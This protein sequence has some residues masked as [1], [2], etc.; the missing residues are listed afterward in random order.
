MT[1]HHVRSVFVSSGGWARRVAALAFGAVLFG[2]TVA[3]HEPPQG[4]TPGAKGG[5]QKTFRLDGKFV[6][7][8]GRIQLQI[9]NIG[10]TGNQD[11][12]SRTT[13]P[14]CEWPPGSGNDYLYAAGLWVGAIDASGIPHV[15]TAL[16]QRE[17]SPEIIFTTP[18]P[19]APLPT[20]QLADVRESYEGIP[21][22]N[23]VISSSVDPDDDGDGFIDEDFPNGLDDDQDGLCDEDYAATG[24]Q[25]LSAEYFDDIPSIR[26]V[27]PEHVPL[28]I[29]VRQT[30]YAWATPGQNDFVGMDYRITNRSGRTLRNVMVAI[31]AD[32]DVGNRGIQGYFVDDQVGLFDRVVSYPG[33]TGETT[34]RRIQMAYAFDNP[35][36]PANPQENKGGD[37]PGYFGCMFLNHTIDPSG[38]TAP[39]H[40]GVTSF[41]YFSGS[42]SFSAGGDPENDAQRYQLMTDPALNPNATGEVRSS[43]PVDYRFIMATGPFRSLLPESTLTISVGWVMGLGL[44]LPVNVPTGPLPSSAVTAGSVVANAISAQQVF[45]GL[46]TDLDGELATGF[47]GKETCLS[48][49][50]G[51]QFTYQP[52]ID[53]DSLCI[54]RFRSEIPN[55]PRYAD[56]PPWDPNQDCRTQQGG[57]FFCMDDVNGVPEHCAS[58]DTSR[59]SINSTTCVYVDRDCDALTGEGG[60]EHLVHWVAASPL[61]APFYPG[62]DGRG[63]PRDFLG[64]YSS[65]SDSAR[66][67]AWF[68][69]GDRK[70]TLKWNNFAEM[71]RDA[72]RGNLKEFIGYRIY[73]AA[74]WD[75]PL[76]TNAPART[77]WSLLGEWRI[78]PTGTA[79]RPLSELIDP[80]IPAVRTD[81]VTVSW[82][83][84]ARAPSNTT[85]HTEIDT[86]F[87]VGRY[88]YTDAHVLNGFPY[89]YS[90][91]PISVVPGNASGTI[92]DVL[93]IG[94]PSATNAQVVYPRSDAQ[95]TQTGVYV[96]PNPY[97]GGAQWDL[98]PREE[99]PSGTK[100]TFHNLPRTKGTIHI[101][102][103]S[104]DLVKDIQFDGT[105]PPDL[106][107]GKDPLTS[108]SGQASW[109]LISRNG[110]K[111]VS[112]IYLF[113]VDTD[114]GREVGKFVIIR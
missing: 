62:A 58:A 50:P 31:F 76:G 68:F 5:P 47:C 89:F 25:M 96:V 99:D 108:G 27:L 26:Q 73:R 41:K 102:T 94:N 40:V 93:L 63:E 87:A 101:F 57:R 35:D 90:I 85:F 56:V 1:R 33:P 79:A 53:S 54:I 52:G 70:V 114:L 10:E 69:P 113:S 51:F 38:I 78:N 107:Y 16:Y 34:K 67:S 42:A 66:V 84:V 60:R 111:I 55:D 19:C 44:G 77:L 49:S 30:S 64:S 7:S 32:P 13:V 98:V 105:S 11:N 104:G 103:L 97:K 8:V 74:G 17:F 83:P 23:R 95:N 80:S 22:G 71:I 88:S 24:Q 2:G 12:P 110:Q 37:A 82:D 112:G 61:P 92:A 43:R 45:D 36:N 14:S 29:R 65:A 72:Q 9:T 3:W 6:H 48:S 4:T 109:N 81:S 75:R 18:P 59:V 91:V 46:Y 15:T 100:V 86:L 20:D 21:G 106:Q 28:G 39:D